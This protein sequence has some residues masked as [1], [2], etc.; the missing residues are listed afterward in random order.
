M[1]EPNP[2]PPPKYE[3]R[4]WTDST[5]KFTVEAKFRGVIN[6]NVRLEKADG[7]TLSIPIKQ[8]SKRDQEWMLSKRDQE[9]IRNR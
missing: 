4:T 7:K 9:W 2:P 1:P 5:G 6:G 3:V 8:L